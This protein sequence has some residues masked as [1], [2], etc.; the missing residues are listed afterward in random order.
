MQE[1][2]ISENNKILEITTGSFL[3]GTNNPES[4]KDYVGIF[5]PTEEYVLGFKRCEEVDFSIIDKDK[6]GKNTNKALDRKLYEFRKFIKLALENNPNILEILFVNQ[7][8]IVFINEIG[9]EL[10]KI[11]HLFLHKGLKQ[12]FCGYAFSQ[13]HKMVIKKDNYFDLNLAYQYILNFDIQQTILEI[14]LDSKCPNFIKLKKHE[15]NRSTNFISIGDLNI[16]PGTQVKK[17]KKILKERLDKVGNREELLLKYGY[18]CKFGMHLLRL[19]LEGIELLETGTLK[20]PLKD[21]EMLKDVRNGK[22]KMTDILDYS[23]ELE[24]KLNTLETTTMLPTKPNS[25]LI[26]E[27]TITQLRKVIYVEN[28]IWNLLWFNRGIKQY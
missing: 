19:M 14:A 13:K 21:G 9:E 25:K 22:W 1:K 10:L 27:F 18:D 23:N 24:N 11:K 16:M 4:D 3:Y 17:L 8:N 2:E 28:N 5:M 26:E 7:D 12:K 6:E 15:N 20:F